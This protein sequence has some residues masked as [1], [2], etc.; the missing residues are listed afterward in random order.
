M[1]I[2]HP[3]YV[4]QYVQTCQTWSFS[5]FIY[6]K[7]GVS[8]CVCV[9]VCESVRVCVAGRSEN[10]EM[11]WDLLHQVVCLYFSFEAFF[12]KSICGSENHIF[13]PP[14][15]VLI[16]LLDLLLNLCSHVFWVC[17]TVSSPGNH[18]E[19]FLIGAWAEAQ[20]LDSSCCNICSAHQTLI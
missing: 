13:I 1:Y 20:L 2:N 11:V 3:A 7:N 10:C 17:T 9:C 12:H 14:A 16:S 4:R 8:V 18:K 15:A 19:E 5:L 6:L